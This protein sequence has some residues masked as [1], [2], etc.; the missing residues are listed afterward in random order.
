MKTSISVSILLIFLAVF[1]GCSNRLVDERDS[2]LSM[3]DI[4]NYEMSVA[5]ISPPA[6]ALDVDTG[7]QIETVFTRDVDPL[8]ITASTFV[9]AD[10]SYIPI[11]GTFS[12]SDPKTVVFTPFVLLN[13]TEYNV[14]ITTDV[15]DAEGNTLWSD[16][17]WNFT[18]I[19]AGTVP[20]PEFNPPAGTYEGTTIVSIGIL[21]PL[22]TIHYTV[23]GSDPTPA[24]PEYT[25][26]ISVLENTILP[27]KAVAYRGGFFDS[28]II[29]AAYTIRVLTPASDPPAGAYS[30]D[31][32]ITIET[33]TPGATIWYTTDGTDPDPIIPNGSIYGGPIALTGPGP[34][35]TTIK[36]LAIKASMAD[37]PILSAD[38]MIDYTQVSPPVFS[39]PIGTYTWQQHVNLSTATPGATIRYTT[40]GSVP[41][42]MHGTTGT[43]VTVND[44]MVLKAFAFKGGMGDSPVTNSAGVPYIIA[45]TL[46]ARSPDKHKDDHPV[47]ITFWG[48]RFKSGV[49]AKLKKSGQP[50]I[51][52]APITIL[53]STKIRGTFNITGVQKGRW[54]VVVTNPDTGTAT[55]TEWFRVH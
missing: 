33:S 22:A 54:D 6:S 28:S 34:T 11:P 35:A 53:S 50:D 24:S 19:S 30:S 10:N 7:T 55:R 5:S 29:P 17:E 36:T 21:D 15:K 14:L 45:P 26:P 9:V 13:L 43:S 16:I 37:S 27:I 3:V 20:D 31:R 32:M 52:A 4:L 25:G 18:T 51:V 8:T 47:T 41:T 2:P 46:S 42:M 39:P 40:D 1:T 44:T 49:T 12:Y 23:D 48:T 38:Y